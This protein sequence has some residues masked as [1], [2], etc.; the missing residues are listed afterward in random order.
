MRNGDS[1]SFFFPDVTSP[2]VARPFPSLL[3]TTAFVRSSG[4]W[5]G[6]FSCKTVPRGLPS[7]TTQLSKRAV[8]RRLFCSWHTQ[9]ESF[10]A[11]CMTRWAL[12]LVICPK[13]DDAFTVVPGEFHVG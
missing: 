13:P 7:S 4:R 9:N 3:P 11:N 1:L 5:F 12:A 8:C 6:T 2:D 10:S